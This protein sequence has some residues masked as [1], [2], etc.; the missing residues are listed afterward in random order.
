MKPC[1]EILCLLQ[2]VQIGDLLTALVE[3]ELL[4]N[5]WRNETVSGNT[6]TKHEM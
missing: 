6:E 1:N 2:L 3:M 5:H 4:E